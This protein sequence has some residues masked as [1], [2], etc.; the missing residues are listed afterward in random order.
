[1]KQTCH[2]NIEGYLAERAQESV[3][4]ENDSGVESVQVFQEMSWILKRCPRLH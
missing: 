2:M 3:T 4:A 1:M